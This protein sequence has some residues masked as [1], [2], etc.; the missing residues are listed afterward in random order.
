M[1]W[2]KKNYSQKQSDILQFE[3]R[4][5]FEVFLTLC[6]WRY[7]KSIPAHNINYIITN[8]LIQE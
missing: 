7:H 3:Q 8:L 2:E 1:I 4:P 5:S 6:M